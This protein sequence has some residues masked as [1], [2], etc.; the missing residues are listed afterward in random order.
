M[1]IIYLL[2]PAAVK[3]ILLIFHF[4]E[5]FKYITVLNI[6]ISDYFKNSKIPTM[7]SLCYQAKNN[8][9]SSISKYRLNYYNFAAFLRITVKM[10]Q[11]AIDYFRW[12]K[13]TLSKIL[14]RFDHIMM[15]C[16]NVVY[17]HNSSIQW[18]LVIYF[19]KIPFTKCL[20]CFI[21]YY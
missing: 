2:L 3:M 11:W 1:I 20:K 4:T 5:I 7:L 6:F 10:L 18:L 17:I 21:D 14:P 16:S 12:V 13:D 15:K 19:T 9:L 8:M